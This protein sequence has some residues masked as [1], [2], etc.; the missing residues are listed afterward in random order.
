M[1]HVLFLKE[2][3]FG[4]RGSAG[5]AEA[6][7]GRRRRRALPKVEQFERVGSRGRGGRRRASCISRRRRRLAVLPHGGRR[8]MIGQT[9]SQQRNAVGVGRWRGHAREMR[10]TSAERTTPE[11]SSHGASYPDWQTTRSTG[12]TTGATGA[13][14]TSPG[15][16]SMMSVGESGG[17]GGDLMRLIERLRRKRKWLT[18]RKSVRMSR[19]RR[20]RRQVVGSVGRPTTFASIAVDRRLKLDRVGKTHLLAFV[21]VQVFHVSV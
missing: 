17:G 8:K 3:Q 20:T 12:G 16:S 5:A 10:R 2:L 19:H 9:G 21:R 14:M 4:R 11:R 18:D 7:S 15:G 6:T 13:M 1:S